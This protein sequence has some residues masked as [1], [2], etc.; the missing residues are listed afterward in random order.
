MIAMGAIFFRQ[1]GGPDVIEEGV[2]PD[3]KPRR[4]E[5]FLRVKA[6]ALNHLDLWVRRGR[7]EPYL[8]LPHVGGSDVAGI[9]E[10][11]GRGVRGVRPGQVGVLN[12]SLWCGRCSYCRRGEEALCDS[13]GIVGDATQ[14]GTAEPTVA[15][16]RNFVPMPRDF[17]FEVAAAFPLTF[18]TAW[19][20]I[21]TRARARKGETA[22]VVCAG[23]GVSSAAIQI[24][25]HLGCRVIA[26]TSTPE[27]ME[28]A[29]KVGANAVINYWT[30][31]VA[32]RAKELTRGRGVDT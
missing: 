6:V 1:C 9:V 18:L 16:A 21:R 26:T 15:P 14:G 13:F 12:P 11:T 24:L 5:I 8:Q 23:G 22:L 7:A 30:E 20:M 32:V 29:K 10:A 28:K 25:R 17:S 3:P 27:K 19:R 31:D 4:G 2:L